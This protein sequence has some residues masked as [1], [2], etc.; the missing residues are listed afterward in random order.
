MQLTQ[1]QFGTGDLEDM[2]TRRMPG[3][4]RRERLETLPS[5]GELSG[6][7]EGRRGSH[8]GSHLPDSLPS[9]RDNASWFVHLHSIS[10]VRSDGFVVFRPARS[11]SS[12]ESPP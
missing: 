6:P 9:V 10:K 4:Q 3:Q 5:Q 12:C 11:I 7:F 8:I 2:A 1:S